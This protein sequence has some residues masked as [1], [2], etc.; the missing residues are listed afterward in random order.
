VVTTGSATT[1]TE[2]TEDVALAHPIPETELETI[3]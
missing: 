3:Q 2:T 1:I